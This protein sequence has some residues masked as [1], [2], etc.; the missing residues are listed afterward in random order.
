MQRPTFCA[1]KHYKTTWAPFAILIS[2]NL[3]SDP[4]APNYKAMVALD[5][6]FR[7]LI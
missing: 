5:L 2:H 7:Y 4:L 3:V 1:H 6:S